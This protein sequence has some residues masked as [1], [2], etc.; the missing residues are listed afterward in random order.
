M[1]WR[2]RRPIS[3]YILKD[4]CAPLPSDERSLK[5]KNGCRPSR[6]L[7]VVVIARRL[8][9]PAF[10]EAKLR[11]RAGRRSN[12]PAAGSGLLRFAGKK[13][14]AGRPRSQGAANRS[15]GILP[16]FSFRTGRAHDRYGTR[17]DGWCQSPLATQ[18]ACFDVSAA[19]DFERSVATSRCGRLRNAGSELIAGRGSGAA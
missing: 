6:G 8:S 14:R 15:A 5:S 10:A 11:L 13:M 19:R 16:A 4:Y 9:R 18:P 17:N 1:I 7:S 2:N 3:L 12:P